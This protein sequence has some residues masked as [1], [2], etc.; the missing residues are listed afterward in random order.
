MA[1][2]DPGRLRRVVS[3]LAVLGTVPYLALKIA[4][5]AGSRAGLEDPDFG[6]GVVMHLANALTLS[7]DAVA[8]LMAA[9]F[10]MPF[11]QRLRPAL[12]LVPMWIGTGLLAPIVVVVPLQLAL[13]V[14]EATTGR[15]SP[16]ADWVFAV[17]YGGFMWQGVFL[18]AGFALYARARWGADGGRT[19]PRTPPSR[20]TVVAGVLLAVASALV[21][22]E[23]VTGDR[24]L[25]NL[26]GDEL[27]LAAAALG[28][29][30]L[31]SV[32]MSRRTVVILVWVGSGAAVA[33]GAYDL[34][35][36][37]VPNDLTEG[38]DTVSI[39][40]A[41]ARLLAGAAALSVLARVRTVASA[42]HPARAL[43]GGA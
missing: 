4:W 8:V 9:A 34:V 5:L 24:S 11:G 37:V 42:S 23:D 3:I 21:W 20:G 18:M 26:L 36:Q 13:G 41:A 22:L 10:V 35:L 29:V 31:H 43:Q 32:R 15:P 28:L 7:M 16:I 40:S 6:R 14:P 12:V 38:G 39:L 30:G 33:W 25:P 27:L 17:V 19:W 1:S 2:S